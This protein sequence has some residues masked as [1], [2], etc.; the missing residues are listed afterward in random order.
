MRQPSLNAVM[1]IAARLGIPA[2]E[3]V[4]RVSAELESQKDTIL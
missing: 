4:R 2:E 3:L 1:L